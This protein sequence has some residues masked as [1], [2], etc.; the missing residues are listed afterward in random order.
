MTHI[1]KFDNF[2]LLFADI[3]SMPCPSVAETID[4]GDDIVVYKGEDGNLT[5][6]ANGIECD[7]LSRKYLCIESLVDANKISSNSGT[8]KCSTDGKQWETLSSSISKTINT[9]EKLYVT[10][11]SANYIGLIASGKFIVSGNV[12]SVAKTSSCRFA[13]LFRRSYNL[14]SAKDLVLPENLAMQD[15]Q[16]MFEECTSLVEGPRLKSQHLGLQCYVSMFDR[17]TSLIEAPILEAKELYSNC[18]YTMF[19]GCTKLEKVTCLAEDISASF[20]LSGWL[21]NV[22]ATGTF[23]KK[24][25]VEYPT[26]KSGIPEG[27]TIIEID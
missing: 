2:D 20:C 13:Q 21:N 9:G 18:Y 12:M 10:D 25:G 26:G 15:C 4:N 8:F 11:K 7:F 16:E 6:T 3:D 5:C 17:C 1:R 24:R 19:S 14:V 27:W 22:S 23:T